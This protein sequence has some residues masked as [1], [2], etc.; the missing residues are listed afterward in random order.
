MKDKEFKFIRAD[1]LQPA[2]IILSTDSGS[3]DSRK[4][5]LLTSGKYSHA[6]LVVDPLLH[7]ESI[8]M[9]IGFTPLY[10]SRVEKTGDQT[11]L[12]WDISSYKNID[13]FRHP[14]IE[15]SNDLTSKLINTV[16]SLRGLEYPELYKLSSATDLLR[17]IP[18]LKEFILKLISKMQGEPEKTSPGMFCSQLVKF[19]MDEIGYTPL[20]V[21]FVNSEVNPNHFADPRVSKLNLVSDIKCNIDKDLNNDELYQK[22]LIK[23]MAGIEDRYQML[24][25][26]VE[27]TV[28][29]K[30]DFNTISSVIASQTKVNQSLLDKVPNVVSE[31]LKSMKEKEN[32]ERSEYFILL[33]S[34]IENPSLPI[35]IKEK[36]L[37]MKYCEDESILEMIDGIEEVRY[38]N[39]KNK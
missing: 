1:L 28:K 39:S 16:H 3:K 15:R 18:F 32:A 37:I 26:E 8:A 2:D 29:I 13:V 27:R 31:A 12:L 17:G 9:G 33:D 35:S 22:S 11:K 25:D 24:S 34:L 19:C 30:K 20:K 6:A 5:S 23:N 38:T 21:D 7:F 36:I 10:I 4:I 14:N